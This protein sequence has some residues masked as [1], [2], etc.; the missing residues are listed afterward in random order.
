MSINYT[1]LLGPYIG[2]EG[3]S[4]EHLRALFEIAREPAQL[5]YQY[6]VLASGDRRAGMQAAAES[7]R[8]AVMQGQLLLERELGFSKLGL[9]GELGRGSLAV[10]RERLALQRYLGQGEL[11]LGRARLQADTQFRVAQLIASLRGPRNAFTQQAVLHGLNSVGLS[12]A[13]DAITQ[14]QA[15]PQFQ[16]DQAPVEPVTPATFTEDTG[17]SLEPPPLPPLLPEPAPT[18]APPESVSL[19]I[20]N[21][22]GSLAGGYGLTYGKGFGGGTSDLARKAEERRIAA[23]TAAGLPVT[24]TTQ[25]VNLDL[26]SAPPPPPAPAPTGTLGTTP[27]RNDLPYGPSPD[28]VYDYGVTPSYQLGTFNVAQTG[29]ALLHEGEA[30]LPANLASTWRA[31]PSVPDAGP[32]AGG[33]PARLRALS[34]RYIGALP[35]PN[36]IVSREWLRLPESTRQ[37]LL[38]GYEAKG[39]DP[40]D[41]LFTI[42]NTLP[43]PRL[44]W[45]Q[46]FAAVLR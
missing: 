24:S 12:R 2:R 44:A 37:F 46:P 23:R 25:A 38:G 19:P 17:I 8:V 33:A 31:S 7:G 3:I 43:G 11:E 26:R 28:F 13:V 32:V 34:Q 16:A 22:T 20:S 4:P 9:Q 6:A 1:E 39:Y 21:F 42:R 35:A 36:K 27:I 40:S 15:L 14:G 29:P 10:D 18:P 41:V 5:A 45:E 30:V